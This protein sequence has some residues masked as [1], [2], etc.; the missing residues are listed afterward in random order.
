VGVTALVTAVYGGYDVL[1]PL[2]ADHG[3]DAAVCVT[4][5]PTLQAAG[6]EVRHVPSAERPRLAAKRPKMVPFDFVDADR[7]VWLDASAEV[8][9]PGFR[10]WCDA[11][12]EGFDLVAW[13]HPE[14]RECLFQEVEYCWAW[15][16][17]RREPLHAQADFY[18]GEGMPERFG[19]WACGTLVWSDTAAAR[20]FG[21]AWLREQERWSIQDQ[22]SLPWLLHTLRP[23]FGVFPGHEF[24]NEWL[25]WH[26]HLSDR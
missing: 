1:R 17:Y 19:L 25:A 8:L 12:S 20:A 21:M 11:A 26:Q 23:L 22:V 14:D 16:K 3:F 15:P 5:D 9:R 10:E 2:P 7:A 13:D 24:Q 18:R 6:W 4:D